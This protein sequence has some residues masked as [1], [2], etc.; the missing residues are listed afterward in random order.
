MAPCVQ[1][2]FHAGEG[3][4]DGGDFVLLVFARRAVQQLPGGV[5]VAGVTGGLIDQ[6]EQHPAQVFSLSVIALARFRQGCE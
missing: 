1:S 2:K 5:G 4:P 3:R 6:V